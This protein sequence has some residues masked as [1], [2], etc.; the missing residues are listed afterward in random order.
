MGADGRLKVFA[1]HR[2]TS[3]THLVGNQ[4]VRACNTRDLESHLSSDAHLC[5]V[6]AGLTTLPRRLLQVG[7]GNQIGHLVVL[8]RQHWQRLGDVLRNPR[9]VLSQ[10]CPNSRP[11]RITF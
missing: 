3:R 9:G 6:G 4:F 11:L 7:P 1:P 2:W 5:T 8:R 10:G